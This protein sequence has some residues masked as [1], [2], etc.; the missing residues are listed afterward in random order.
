MEEYLNRL[1]RFG[2]RLG[3]RN[4]ASFLHLLGNPQKKLRAVHIGGTN[5]KGST[6][7]F[8]ASILRK[9]GHRVGLYTSPHIHDVRER[10]QINGK[11]ISKDRLDDLIRRL[12]GIM[13]GRRSALPVTYFEFLTALSFQYFLEEDI[14]IAVIEVGMGGR[15]DA[16]NLIHPLVSVIST[17]SMDHEEYLGNTL[18]KIA[19]EKAGIVKHDGIVVTGV[20]QRD[21]QKMFGEICKGKKSQIFYYA[22]D[23]YGR[24]RAGGVCDYY[25]RT[26]ALSGLSLGLRGRHQGRNVSLAL[27]SI[28]HLREKGFKA[29]DEAVLA[30]IK[31]VQWPCRLEVVREK[32]LVVLDGAHNSEGAHVLSIAL[33]EEFFWKRLFL[34][35]GVLSDKDYSGMLSWIS[36]LADR[37]ILTRPRSDR[38]LSPDIIL[39]AL[40]HLSRKASIVSDP[41]DAV[42]RALNAARPDDCICVCGSLFTAAAGRKYLIPKA[43]LLP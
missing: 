38:A 3:L 28:E 6:A 35:F 12:K 19:R 7:A 25:G 31:D 23:F 1:Q 37:V 43:L 29:G 14:D 42:E 34:V 26:M 20:W 22:Q 39:N 24:Y 21:L 40:P 15:L 41:G 32:P 30:G 5:G 17:V 8:I 33:K 13:E 10:I 18:V 16:T 2:V 4:V 36:P 11:Y 27:A 9:A